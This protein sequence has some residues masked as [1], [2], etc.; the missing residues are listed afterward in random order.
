M[1]KWILHTAVPKLNSYRSGLLNIKG[2][3]RNNHLLLDFIEKLYDWIGDE[4]NPNF[5][6]NEVTLI[7]EAKLSIFSFLLTNKDLNNQTVEKDDNVSQISTGNKK[8]RMM[9]IKKLKSAKQNRDAQ[10][11]D[12]EEIEV[13]IL[14]ILGRLGGISHQIVK[15]EIDNDNP[16]IGTTTDFVNIITDSKTGLKFDLF[17][18]KF[19][20]QIDLQSILPKVIEL[21]SKDPDSDET[22]A[23]IDMLNSLKENIEGYNS[24][25]DF[26]N[27]SIDGESAPFK[28]L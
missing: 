2:D 20:I 13:R 22:I 8:G 7:K 18:E 11:R 14:S 17:L 12:R 1:Q 19:G 16:D 15:D 27:E 24:Q 5:N 21:A 9:A 6:K 3:Q 23:A 10:R 25:S 4:N 26:L 28:D